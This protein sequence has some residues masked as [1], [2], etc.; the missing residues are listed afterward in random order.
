M[1]FMDSCIWVCAFLPQKMVLCGKRKGKLWATIGLIKSWEGYWSLLL[2]YCLPKCGT[3]LSISVVC[4]LCNW[5]VWASLGLRSIRKQSDKSQIMF[6]WTG[7][8]GTEVGQQCRGWGNMPPP[9][10]EY[11]PPSRL[12][13]VLSLVALYTLWGLILRMDWCYPCCWV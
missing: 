10:S 2:Q 5:Q 12:L 1:P 11:L 13:P 9:A 4:F 3:K 7:S 8:W 6:R